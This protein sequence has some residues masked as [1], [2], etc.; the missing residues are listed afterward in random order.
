MTKEETGSGP[1]RARN[2]PRIVGDTTLDRPN[3][4]ALGTVQAG[5]ARAAA[6]VEPHRRLNEKLNTVSHGIGVVLA[7]IGLIALLEASK[8]QP[9]KVLAFSIYGA[10]MIALYSSSTALHLFHFSVRAKRFLR[11][12]DHV[13][14]YLFIAGTHT[15]LCAITLGDNTGWALLGVVWTFAFFGVV[16][17]L[18]YLDAPRWLST[19]TYLAVGWLALLLLWPLSQV[20]PTRALT[21][22][23]IGGAL[24][25]LGSLMFLFRRPN[26]FP[27]RLGY[28]ELWHFT[29][30]AASGCH[31]YIMLEYVARQPV[32]NAF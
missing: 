14:I 18:F 8:G 9:M 17:K 7:V 25:T 19:T 23:I 22:L 16:F 28:H 11:R 10:T 32:P 1:I 4:G 30:L 15:P 2:R 3:S 31:F 21:W 6:I 20:L 29:V 26:P 24:Y 13:A 5:S 27:G 12:L